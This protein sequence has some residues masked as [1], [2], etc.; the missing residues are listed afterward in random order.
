VARTR[1][2]RDEDAV[3][4]VV[5]QFATLLETYGFP[6]MSGR[7]IMA[8]MVTEAPGLTAAELAETLKVSPAAISTSMRY[9]LAVGLVERFSVP[10]QRRVRYRLPDDAWYLA[11]ATKDPLY[12]RIAD[13]AREGV[14]A[15]GGEGTAPGARLEQMRDFFSYLEAEVPALVERWH[16][17]RTR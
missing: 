3:A 9:P 7:I 2:K 15:V 8:L 11:S 16:E 12:R 5:E 1:P 13:L 4:H 10:G 6:R 17:Q 14:A